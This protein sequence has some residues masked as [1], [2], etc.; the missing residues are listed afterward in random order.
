MD[1]TRSGRLSE[2][3]KRDSQKGVVVDLRIEG[4]R[5]EGTRNGSTIDEG[6]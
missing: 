4:V 1:E 3:G 2:S 6:G 5:T